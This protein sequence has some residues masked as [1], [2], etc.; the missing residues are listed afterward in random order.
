MLLNIFQSLR[1]PH[2]KGLFGQNVNSTKNLH[3]PFL[4]I[5]LVTAPSPSTVQTSLCFSCVFTFL[6]IKKHNNAEN[7]FSSISSIKM[8]AQKFANF[9][10][11]LKMHADM[12]AVT[13][14][15]NKIVSNEVKDN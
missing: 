3:K 6:E 8:D 10:K 13:I 2:S 15:S 11:F 9:D 12:T 14:Q 7:V 5:R 4:Y 1:Q